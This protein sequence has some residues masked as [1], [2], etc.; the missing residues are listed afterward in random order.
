[1]AR[2]KGF[3]LNTI[4][5]IDLTIIH[6]ISKLET[7]FHLLFLEN[8]GP[9]FDLYPKLDIELIFK[10]GLLIK[11]KSFGFRIKQIKL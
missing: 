9:I 6:F 4:G 8:P 2:C 10:P 11:R 1:M 7:F 5:V 3:E